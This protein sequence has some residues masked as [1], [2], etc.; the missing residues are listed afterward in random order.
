MLDAIVI[1]DVHLGSS[2]CLTDRLLKFLCNLPDTKRLIINGDLT[3]NSNPKL[4]NEQMSVF[5]QIGLLAVS[6]EVIWVTGNHDSKTS[7]IANL[8]NIKQ[9]TEY[10]FPTGGINCLCIHGHQWDDFLLAH[11]NWAKVGDWIYHWLQK[12]D[13]THKL[14][15]WAK[16]NNKSYM[17]CIEKIRQGSKAYGIDRGNGIVC[18]GHTHLAE[19]DRDSPVTYV[20]TGCWTEF[21]GSYV[22]IKDGVAELKYF[23]DLLNNPYDPFSDFLRV[24]KVILDNLI[25]MGCK[26]C[27]QPADNTLLSVKDENREVVALC[28]NC[29]DKIV[30][31]R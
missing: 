24:Q 17:N 15:S 27:G 23:D 19:I 29:Y 25:I 28:K 1:S 16:R 5:W 22:A 9:L 31:R 21:P 14:A 3:D 26:K 30:W 18:C 20:N 11:P 10:S 4:S 2:M 12:I 13:P 7:N 8:L 6:S